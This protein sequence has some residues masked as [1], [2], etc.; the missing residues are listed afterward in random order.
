MYFLVGSSSSLLSML[1]VKVWIK[2]TFFL[3]LP[4]L[5]FRIS[6]AALEKWQ[7]KKKLHMK[8]CVS[9]R[10]SGNMET[11]SDRRRYVVT[12]VTPMSHWQHFF[13]FW[14]SVLFLFSYY[15]NSASQLRL[16]ETKVPNHFIWEKKL[17][18]VWIS[19]SSSV[20]RLQTYFGNVQGK[21]NWALKYESIAGYTAGAVKKVQIKPRIINSSIKMMD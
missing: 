3:F 11:R 18:N 19:V 20:R 16:S 9:V 6:P 8:T 5:W 12:M 14:L 13:C 21:N 1:L 2:L 7:K 10:N 15:I 4:S 17:I